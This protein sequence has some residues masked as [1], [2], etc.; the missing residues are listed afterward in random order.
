MA[1]IRT[2]TT[3]KNLVIAFFLYKARYALENYSGKASSFLSSP[4]LIFPQHN[5]HTVFS[6]SFSKGAVSTQQELKF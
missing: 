6:H 1:D 2:A 3:E 4:Y 5:P